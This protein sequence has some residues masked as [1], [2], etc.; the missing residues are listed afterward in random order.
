MA[1]AALAAGVLA[2]LLLAATPSSQAAGAPTITLLAPANGAT[3]VS[4]TDSYPTATAFRTRR[5]TA[6]GEPTA[7]SATPTTTARAT[8]VS[9][10]TSSRASGSQRARPHADTTR[11]CGCAQQTTAAPSGSTSPSPTEATRCT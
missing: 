8:P 11:S 4:T 5:T 10:T 6:R 3:I 2:V 7:T 9:P 1:R